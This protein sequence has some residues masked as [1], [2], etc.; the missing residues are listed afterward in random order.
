MQQSHFWVFLKKNQSQDL[1]EILASCVLC[2]ILRKVQMWKQLKC[3][4][5]D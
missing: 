3:P 1:E 2:S 5:M 4:W